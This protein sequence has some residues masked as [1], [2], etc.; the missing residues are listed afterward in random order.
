MKTSQNSRNILLGIT[1]SEQQE[2]SARYQQ[3]NLLHIAEII[4]SEQSEL[5]YSEIVYSEQQKQYTPYN[6]PGIAKIFYSVEPTRNSSNSLL[7]IP[8]WNSKNILLR[9]TYFVQLGSTRYSW[10]YRV[11]L[12]IRTPPGSPH[13][14]VL[15]N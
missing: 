4:Y 12:G 2:C 15:Q 14:N 8:T 5:V 3:N 13:N 10:L 1:Y 11:V 7:R 9:I 6:P